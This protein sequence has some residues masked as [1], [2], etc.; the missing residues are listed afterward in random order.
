MDLE[1]LEHAIST[2]NAWD[3]ILATSAKFGIHVTTLQCHLFG[4]LIY[5][6]EGKMSFTLEED[7]ELV[8]F[9]LRTAMVGDPLLC[10]IHN[11]NYCSTQDM[12]DVRFQ[13]Q[14]ISK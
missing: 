8:N 13:P 5:K 4:I 6:L 3:K 11:T 12:K 2:I 9:K 7:D 10:T 1:T 14:C